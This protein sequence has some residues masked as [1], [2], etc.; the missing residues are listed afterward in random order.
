MVRT[1]DP[2]VTTELLCDGFDI[3]QSDVLILSAAATSEFDQLSVPQETARASVAYDGKIDG[4]MDIL[5]SSIRL[6]TIVKLSS[7]LQVIGVLLGFLLSAF[8][9]FYGGLYNLNG[10]T[11][12][13]F[14]IFWLLAS[15]IPS[16]LRSSN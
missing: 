12:L 11:A 14:Q 16:L 7:V 4:L 13:L 8:L 15:L 10:A 2:N 5:S 3:S 1:C 6:G 9:A